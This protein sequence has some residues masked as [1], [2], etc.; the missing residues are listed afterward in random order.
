MLGLNH[1]HSF[2]YKTGKINK[3]IKGEVGNTDV[4]H[5]GQT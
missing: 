4:I 5:T 1:W 2:K 3:M